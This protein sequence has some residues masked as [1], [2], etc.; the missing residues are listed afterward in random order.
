MSVVAK[1]YVRAIEMV[2]WGTIIKMSPVTKGSA[3]N[4]AFFAATPAGTL[5]FT[6][7]NEL[8]AERFHLGHEY[9]LTFME[10]AE[11]EA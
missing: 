9:W 10:A 7:K 3:E 11:P 5:E 1:F 8:A 2:Q 4:E 6:I